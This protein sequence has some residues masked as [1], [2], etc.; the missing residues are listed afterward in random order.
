MKNTFKY[1]FIAACSL[2]TVVSCARFDEQEVPEQATKVKMTFTAKIEGKDTEVDTKTVLGGQMGDEY[3]KVLWQPEDSIGIVNSL[4]YRYMDKFVN[5]EDEV[6][7]T[8]TFTGSTNDGSTF[9]MFYPYSD[10]LYARDYD[11]IEFVIPAGQTYAKESFTS[12]AMPMVGKG[13]PQEIV[14]FYSLCGVLALNI[15]GSE[16]IQSISFTGKDASGF[17]IPITGEYYVD[18]SSESSYQIYTRGNNGNTVTL[19]CGEGVEVNETEATPFYIVL[20]TGTYESFMLLISTTDGKVMMKESTKPLTIKRANVT[21]TGALT[22]VANETINLS[23]LG[24]ANCYIVTEPGLYSIDATV[25]GNGEFG[26]VDKAA[27]HTSRTS[28]SPIAAELLWEDNSGIID[29]VTPAGDK[30]NFIVTGYEG[31]ALVA[32]KDANG[33]I[34]WSWHIWVTD[35]PQDQLYVNST[36]SYTM[37][38]RNLG[39]TSASR[40]NGEQW[41]ESVGLPYQWG[42]KDPFA[43]GKYQSTSSQLYLKETVQSPTYFAYGNDKWAKDWSQYLWSPDQKTIYDPCPAG[44]RVA[45][46]EVWSGFTV[47]GETA[48]RVESMNV[49]DS[50]D[51]GWNFYINDTDETAWYP[52]TVEIG[53][54]GDT[55]YSND[56]GRIWSATNDGGNYSKHLG[57]YYYSEYEC[58]VNPTEGDTNPM[59]GH[60]VRCMKDELITAVS[61]RL[62]SVTDATVNSAKASATIAVQGDIEIERSG[63]IYGTESDITLETGNVVNSENVYGDIDLT[64]E[65]LSPYTKYF[66]KAFAVTTEGAVYYSANTEVFVTLTE[67]GKLNL[68]SVGTANSYMLPPLAMEYS[69]NA[70]VIGNGDFGLVEGANFHTTTT[71]ISPASAELLWEDRTGLIVE[72]SVKFDGANITFNTTGIKG[73]AV[74]AAKNE[75]GKILW[76]WHIWVTDVTEDHIYEN[77][78]GTFVV[79]DRNLGATRGDKGVGEQWKESTG[80]EYLWGRKDP[81]AGGN[82]VETSQYYYI[83]DGILHPTAKPS[84]WERTESMWRPDMKTIYDPCPVGYRVASNDIWYGFSTSATSG[85]FENGWYFLYNGVDAAWYPTLG[86]AYPTYT[87]YWGD[88]YMV[89]STY[90]GGFYFAS[91]NSYTTSIDAGSLRCMKD[92]NAN[93]VTVKIQSVTDKTS[94]TANVNASIASQGNISIVSAGIVYGTSSALTTENG[95]KVT[96]DVTFGKFT[97]AIEGLAPLTKYYVRAFATADDGNTYY[98]S[99]TL[100]FITPSED[101]IVNLSVG[102][103]AN[104]YIV[105]PAKGIYTFDLVKGNSSESVGAVDTVEVLW[106]TYNNMYEVVA[107]TVVSSA[108]VENGKAK[109]EIPENVVPGN[110][111]IAAKDADGTILWSWHIWVA[112]FDPVMTQQTYRS[113]AVMMDRN[114]GAVS[115]K[116]GSVESYGF[117]YQWG[118][119]DP[120]VIPG[121]MTTAPADAIVYDYYD[122]SNDTIENA[123]QNPTTVYDDARWNERNELWSTGTSKTIYDPCPVGWKVS[124]KYAWDG[125]RRADNSQLGYF[126]LSSESATP[127]AYIPLP[128]YSEGSADIYQNTERGRIWLSERSNM[129]WFWVWNSEPGHSSYYS[130]DELMGVRCMKIEDGGKPGSGDDYIVDDDYEWE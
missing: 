85:A 129:M 56:T 97:S 106:E 119:K 94:T 104:S 41:R 89:S 69:F 28:I 54:W 1:I 30:I 7:E 31:N 82:L 38:D 18:M 64:M 49:K 57:Y 40:G 130:V 39:A 13:N 78:L 63:I 83:T 105:L 59:Y 42:R 91:W 34:L 52:V 37:L 32:A 3:R 23:E 124:D 60:P 115:V 122:S 26:M 11:R 14:Q 100:S 48:D 24:T 114:L 35:Q 43:E 68:S 103:T 15:T 12:N 110:A 58:W 29:G 50:F 107:G 87:S 51:Y 66:V 75:G 5:I 22:Y 98:S 8:G 70:T 72:G 123:V 125:L 65:D 113:G 81:F 84:D 76:S 45:V 4:G 111:L 95:T 126:Q 19:S 67:D 47:N 55:Y 33:K 46:R 20:P 88:C 86:K 53:Y 80:L 77:D 71:S 101:G 73:N 61:V 6:S 116:P 92:E 27:F 128:G 120:F 117:F 79:Q 9:Y 102:G 108:T 90:R 118:R 112:D 44:Y 62:H 127:T 21:K 25:I 109:F 74:I 121:Y 96:T 10:K 16:T 36:G 99:N 17:P 2:A 93:S